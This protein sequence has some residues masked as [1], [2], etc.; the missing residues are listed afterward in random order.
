MTQEEL[1]ALMSGDID[2]DEAYEETELPNVSEQEDEEKEESPKEETYDPSDPDTYRIS[3]MN[4][5]PPP[6]TDDNKVV[7]QLD[8][9]TKESEE[10]ASEIFDLIEGIS[11]DLSKGEKEIK[12]VQAVIKSNLELFTTLSAKFPHVE[13]FKT[14][15]TQ[16][17]EAKENLAAV[18]N[19]LQDG[20]DTIMTIM[21]IMQYQ[22]IHR[23]KIERV[24]NVMRAL[25]T[26]M[27]HLF[28]GKIDDAKRVSSAVHIHG[29][30]STEDIV[31]SD[32]I[33]ALLASFGQK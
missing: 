26:Y 8:D 33:E 4:N 21:D 10:K 11:N 15:L 6:P 30:T 19:K 25:S 7:H 1:D 32:D 17:E 14:Q 29:D 12:A 13:A 2:L 18:L 20:G 22:D 5:W 3:A 24:I 28:S 27:N 31:S 23:Q 9:V 16:N